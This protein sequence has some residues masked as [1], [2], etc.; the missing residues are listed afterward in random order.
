VTFI[1]TPAGWMA[2][3]TAG[4]W[5]GS[6]TAY[7]YTWQR[8]NSTLSRCTAIAGATGSTYVLRQADAG[9]RLRVVVTAKNATGAASVASSATT[10]IL[11]TLV[12]KLG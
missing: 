9:T 7:A 12:S 10:I 2:R 11:K 5:T 8:C 6:P 4:T 3:A 1:N